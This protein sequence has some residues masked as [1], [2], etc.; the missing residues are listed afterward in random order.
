[1]DRP[2]KQV[3]EIIMGKINPLALFTQK[4]KTGRISFNPMASSTRQTTVG[5]ALN[6]ILAL[7]N[8]E[9]SLYITP[10]KIRLLQQPRAAACAIVFWKTTGQKGY[11]K[12][13]HRKHRFV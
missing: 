2:G 11:I 10:K 3:D 12:G 5:T 7:E 1:M 6:T 4:E 13:F 9:T 8:V